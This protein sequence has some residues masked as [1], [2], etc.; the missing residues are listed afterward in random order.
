MGDLEEAICEVP[1]KLRE[2]ESAE[3]HAHRIEHATPGAIACRP[4]RREEAEC[5]SLVSS[6]TSPAGDGTLAGR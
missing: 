2:R 3:S 5:T 6:S 4:G 1:N